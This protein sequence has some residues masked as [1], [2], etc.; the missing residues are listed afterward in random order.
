M[1]AGKLKVFVEESFSMADAARAWE[2][3][4][5]GHTRGKLIIKVSEGPTHKRQ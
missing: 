4:R 3:S 1:D 5:A 2:K